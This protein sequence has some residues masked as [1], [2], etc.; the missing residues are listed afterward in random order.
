M[1]SEFKQVVLV[2]L[3][4]IIM[5]LLELATLV[6]KEQGSLGFKNG[7]SQILLCLYIAY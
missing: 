6:V 7:L 2:P 5:L 3:A 1:K 4:I